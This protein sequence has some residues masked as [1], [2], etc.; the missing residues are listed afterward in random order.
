M[1]GK[2]ILF[3]WKD[4][5]QSHNIVNVEFIDDDRYRLVEDSKA[6]HSGEPTYNS[7]FLYTFEQ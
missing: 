7:N 5:N 6:F 3:D 1:K 2:S 4:T